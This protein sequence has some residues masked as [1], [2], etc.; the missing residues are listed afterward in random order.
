MSTL[1][2]VTKF[3]ADAPESEVEQKFLYPLLAHRN[4]LGIL[5]ELIKPQ[6]SIDALFIGKG[7]TKKRYAP[8]HLVHSGGHPVLVCEAKR[9]SANVELGLYEAQLYAHQVNG[10]Y[11]SGFNPIEHVLATNGDR[12]L[13][14]SWDSNELLFDIRTEDLVRHSELLGR[15]RRLIGSDA[16][17]ERAAAFNA[18]LIPDEWHLP[19]EALGESRVAVAKV[20]HNALYEAVEP[21]L[22]AYFDPRNRAH[23]DQ[24]IREAYVTTN[25]RSRY[26]RTFEDFLRTKVVP[27]NDPSGVEIETDRRSAGKFQSH[28]EGALERHNSPY[29]QLVIGSV[30]AGKTT[31]IR[32]FFEQILTG[33]VRHKIVYCRINFNNADDDLDDLRTWVAEQ[34]IECV[35]THHSQTL[36]LDDNDTV[37]K[38]FAPQI[39][40][41]RAA[42]RYLKKSSMEAYYARVADDMLKWIADKPLYAKCIARHLSGDR[43]V[44]LV[45]VFDNVDR[46]SRESQLR[47]FQTGQWFMNQ[48]RA[49]CVMTLRDET[50][51]LY[52][53]EKPLDA[54]LKT[55]NFYISAPRFVDMVQKRL[56][57]ALRNMEDRSSK[58]IEVNIDGLGRLSFPENDLGTFLSSIHVDLFRQRRNITFVLEGLAGKNARQALEMFSAILTSAHFP[59]GQ[60]AIGGLSQGRGQIKES[61]LLK[62]LMRTNYLYYLPDHGFLKNIQSTL[63]EDGRGDHFLKFALLEWLIDNRKRPG[64]VRLEGYFTVDFVISQ[65]RGRGYDPAL[66]RIALAELLRDELINSDRLILHA[67]DDR[68]AVRASAAGFIHARTLLG[69]QEYIAAN[70][71]ITPLAD[72]LV[73]DQIGEKWT[74]AEPRTDIRSHSKTE[75]GEAYL[76]YL[77]TQNE[78]NGHSDPARAMM[79]NVIEGA[80]AFRGH[81]GTQQSRDTRSRQQSEFA[82]KFGEA[83]G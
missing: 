71:L 80:L 81:E 83:S 36:D 74:I 42:Y 70:A 72:K 78:G 17:Q 16:L 65:F 55:N 1:D 43:G 48:L 4:Y 5:H 9:P 30:G 46:R 39:N 73:A 53:N 19:S 67:L 44:P 54:F 79:I 76:R 58:R 20:G 51:E 56:S 12:L 29:M 63:H 57:L 69:R 66:I 21:I 82:A 6:D 45:I 27:S 32:R 13:V 37:D 11:R 33:T 40:E 47:I 25:E 59:T 62:S 26:E 50:Y 14:A 77:R 38:V 61:N 60:F 68:D 15:L 41:N 22:R 8:D 24:I 31:F 52:K 64:N 18:R 49:T 34:F 3:E 35:R 10:E 23:E 7:T 2:L 28:F 75:V